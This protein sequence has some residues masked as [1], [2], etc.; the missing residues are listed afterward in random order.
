[1]TNGIYTLANDVVYD[2]LVAL[3]NSIE[4][5]AGED[6]PVCVIPYDDRLEKVKAEI[7]T[8]KNVMLF[9][10][11]SVIERW[12][13]FSTQAW[14]YHKRAQKVWKQRG[15]PPVY[16]LAM[17]RK[18]CGIDGPFDKFIYFDADTLLMGSLTLIYDKLNDYDWV[19]YDFQYK[20][21]LKYI[22]DQPLEQLVKVFP[23]EELKS[24]IFCAGWFAS[25]KGVFLDVQLEQLLEDLKSGEAD[26][27]ALFGPDQSLFNYMVLRSK[28]PYYNFAYHHVEHAT[29]NHWSSQFEDIDHVLYDHGK[30]LTYLHYMSI[31][32]SKFTELCQG[33]DV[34]IAYK[35]LFLYYRYLNFPEQRPQKFIRPSWMSETSTK[36][37]QFI[38]QKFKN[39]KVKI[40]KIKH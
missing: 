20:S 9:E 7:S 15:L 31:P 10:D 12:E 21:D 24:N 34:D 33:Y 32:S 11:K 16:R 5:N 36:I 23:G 2:Q 14:K 6:I 26:V 38:Q 29:G 27:M 13:N 35:N 25:K 28:I 22:F 19:T 4:A 3:L 1:M 39:M 37:K 30:R 8:R 17:H 40:Q 18:L